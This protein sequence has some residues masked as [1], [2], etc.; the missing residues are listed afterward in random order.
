[1][2]APIPVD[3]DGTVLRLVARDDGPAL[4][5][6]YRRN[7]RHLAPWEPTRSPR[8][9]EAGGQSDAV[10][11]ALFAHRSGSSLPLVLE[12]DGRIVGRVTVANIV[13]G[14]F[15]SADLGYWL[16]DSLQGR[17][18][19]TRAV[20][21][22]LLLARDDLRL[23]RVQAGTLVHNVGS[24]TVLLRNGFERIGVA[25]RY[26][27]I[28]GDWQDHVLFQALLE[29]RPLQPPTIPLVSG[30]RRRDRPGT[31]SGRKAP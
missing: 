25:R 18:L 9:F 27:R 5:A 2:P 6:A 29:D 7:R 14:A 8:F 31:P 19:M 3:D 22:A 16:D 12:R 30:E 13:R 1:M 23:H 28:A 20:G 11:D 15:D 4:A 10:A 17:G 21:A 26:L 24:Q